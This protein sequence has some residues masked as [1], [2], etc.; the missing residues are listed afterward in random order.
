MKIRTGF[1][2][3]SSSSSYIVFGYKIENGKNVLRD[4]LSKLF[5]EFYSFDDKKK[6][7]TYE[8]LSFYNDN[9][10][11]EWF[12]D[13]NDVLVGKLLAFVSGGE[14]IEKDINEILELKDQVEEIGR[15]ININ[16][17]PKLILGINENN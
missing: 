12:V 7:E 3:N 4:I 15:K 9:I 6:K 17:N 1:V 11:V 16:Y 13:H 8:L 10:Y 2:S 14:L 5:P